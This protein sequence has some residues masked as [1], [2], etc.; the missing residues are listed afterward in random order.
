MDLDGC[1]VVE[2]SDL[3]PGV[4]MASG[5]VVESVETGTFRFGQSV[6]VL[7]RNGSA[8]TVGGKNRVYVRSGSVVL[9][10]E[11]YIF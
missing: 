9:H 4:V 10:R 11:D 8:G 3:A 1:V 7:F 2:V 6:H 5:H